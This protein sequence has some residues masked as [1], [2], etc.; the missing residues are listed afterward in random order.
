MTLR[1]SVITVTLNSERF[2]AECLA[3]VAAQGDSLY[4]HIIVDGGSVDATLEIVKRHAA[5]DSRIRWISEP[6]RGISDAMNKGVALAT[7]EVITHLNSD[8]YY[9]H[10]Q[11]LSTCPGLFLPQPYKY[12]ADRRFYICLRGRCVHPRYQ[13]T[14]IL[15][16]TLGTW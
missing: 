16:Q 10:P 13:S 7:G 6:D 1:I 15:L 4:E 8:D 11:V 12:V 14:K 9:P 3:S 2:L 5:N